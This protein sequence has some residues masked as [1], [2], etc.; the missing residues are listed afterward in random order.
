MFSRTAL[1]RSAQ[2]AARRACSA[3]PVRRRGFAAA[4]ASTGAFETLDVS[5]LKIASRDAHGPTTKL[6]IVA[7]A[8]TRFQPLPGLTVGLEEF[9]FKVSAAW[10]VVGRT[11]EAS[12]DADMAAEHAKAVCPP[13]H[14]RVGASRRPIDGVAHARGPGARS[15][16]PPRGSALLCRAAG[17]GGVHDQVHE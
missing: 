4:A 6:A 3:Q 8:G 7:R 17:R 2:Q 13:H 1:A 15:Q 11:A 12:D 14:A 5:G 9:A 16:L 10:P